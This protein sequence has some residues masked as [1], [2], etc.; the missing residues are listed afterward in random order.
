MLKADA[1]TEIDDSS[2]LCLLDLLDFFLASFDLAASLKAFATTFSSCFLSV[3]VAVED[4]ED[5]FLSSFFSVTDADAVTEVE[6][7]EESLSFCL[8]LSEPPV[9]RLLLS[10]YSL[11][12]PVLLKPGTTILHEPL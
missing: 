5:D 6:T 10:E 11:V 4:D 2:F 1:E 9:K 3:T 12:N 7:V 8:S